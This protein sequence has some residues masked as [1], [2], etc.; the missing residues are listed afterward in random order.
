VK[1]SAKT[2]QVAHAIIETK[3]GLL[4]PLQVTSSKLQRIWQ[5]I[6]QFQNGGAFQI[7]EI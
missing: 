6:A 4:L 5:K 3:D 1:S 7:E 2:R